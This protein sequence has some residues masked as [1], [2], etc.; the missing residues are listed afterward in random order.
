[1]KKMPVMLFNEALEGIDSI[2]SDPDKEYVLKNDVLKLIHE[3]GGCDAED[4][5]GKGFDA[6]CDNLYSAVLSMEPV[7]YGPEWVPAATPPREC[8]D[9]LICYTNGDQDVAYREAGRWWLGKFF[10]DT[11]DDADVVAWRPLPKSVGDYKS[12]KQIGTLTLYDFMSIYTGNAC[13]SIIGYCEEAEYDYFIMPSEEEED[14]KGNNPNRYIPSCLA[15]ESWWGEVKDR[16]ITKITVIGGGMYKV[17]LC[18][19][20][21]DD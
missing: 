1:M 10:T 18:I 9:V 4:Q 8:C 17:E 21:K 13:I 19:W 20:L 5:W 7:G 2:K 14:F 12:L 11:V 15:R 16:E 3:A 6:S